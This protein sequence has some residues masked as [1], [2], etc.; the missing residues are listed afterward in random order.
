[1]NE[2]ARKGGMNGLHHMM[3]VPALVRKILWAEQV[4]YDAVIQSNT[5]DPGIDAGR[6]AVTI[7]VIGLLRTAMHVGLNLADRIG[8]TVPVSNH[9]PYT[10]RILRANGLDQFVSG[11]RPLP[12]GAYGGAPDDISSGAVEV[13]RTLVDETGAELVLPLGGAFIPYVVDPVEL[14]REVGVAVLN[15]KS[16]G[17]RF[18]E[19]CVALGLTQSARAYPR[20]TVNRE[21]FGRFAAG[22]PG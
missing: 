9:I 3:G 7:P 4:G 2:I 20:V 22:R 6:L 16:I 13:I 14:E 15:T 21:D 8:I 12:E 11:I 1:V 10:W 18:T 19:M 5:F 17:I